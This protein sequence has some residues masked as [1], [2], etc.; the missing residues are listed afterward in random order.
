MHEHFPLWS[1]LGWA[2]NAVLELWI[3]YIWWQNRKRFRLTALFPAFVI[4]LLASDVVCFIALQV[5]PGTFAYWHSYWWTQLGES[6]LRALVAIQIL[7]DTSDTLFEYRVKI[8]LWSMYIAFCLMAIFA[9]GLPTGMT[10]VMLQMI[11]ISDLLSAIVLEVA[12]CLPYIWWHEAKGYSALSFGL[13]FSMCSDIALFLVWFN[14]GLAYLSY[15]RAALPLTGI[16]TLVLFVVAATVS[17][18][19]NGSMNRESTTA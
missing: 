18:K 19:P 3:I 13:L 2:L 12:V 6:A 10:R 7:S 1:Y 4:F 11:I 17:T 5:F 16:V 8:L 9:L 15:I 14:T